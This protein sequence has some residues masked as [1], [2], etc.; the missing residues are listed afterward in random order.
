[1]LMPDQLQPCNL[2]KQFWCHFKAQNL[3]SK[4]SLNSLSSAAKSQKYTSRDFGDE[5]SQRRNVLSP[6][7]HQLKWKNELLKPIEERKFR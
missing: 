3:A 2:E 7:Q 1:M 6:F 5:M 4:M